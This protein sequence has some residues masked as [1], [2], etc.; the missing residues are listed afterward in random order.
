[1]TSNRLKIVC[2]GLVTLAS[3]V[4]LAAPSSA[5]T[6]DLLKGNGNFERPGI[7]SEARTFTAGSSFGGWQVSG[8]SVALLQAF[9]G[10]VTPPQGAQALSLNPVD[11]VG[12][13][14]VGK[15][16]RTIPTIAGHRYAVSFFGAIA[17]AGSARLVVQIGANTKS[18]AGGPGALPVVWTRYSV[19]VPAAANN[20]A[21]C[22]TASNVKAG[23]FPL[24]DGVKV[25]DRGV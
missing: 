3:T 19:T 7:T 13:P 24:L 15:V 18:V 2:L 9:A 20:A 23:A 4:V 14:P 17:T 25:V 11:G 5:V 1:M 12:G 21:F 16:C 10:L 6:T 22:L 8:A